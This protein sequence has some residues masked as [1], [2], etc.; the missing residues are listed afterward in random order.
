MVDYSFKRQKRCSSKAR[1][2]HL[3]MVLHCQ[4]SFPSLNWDLKKAWS[5][6]EQVV[7][8]WAHEK[9]RRG[10]NTNTQTQLWYTTVA[11]RKYGTFLV[12]TVC[13]YTWLFVCLLNFSLSFNL[14]SHE[15]NQRNW[16]KRSHSVRCLCSQPECWIPSITGDRVQRP[17]CVTTWQGI[18]NWRKYSEISVLMK[19][20]N[21]DY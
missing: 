3:L 2:S 8:R 4:F 16:E 15:F 20:V 12:Q 11:L 5:R 19:M 7:P 6:A 14:R 1:L 9:N 21:K 17:P 13:C 18:Q 10:E